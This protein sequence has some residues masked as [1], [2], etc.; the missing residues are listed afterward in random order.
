MCAYICVYES[1][2]ECIRFHACEIR[3]LLQSQNKGW[4][5]L[6]AEASS[7]VLR[8]YYETKLNVSGEAVRT[9][10]FIFS[11]LLAN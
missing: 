3:V 4:H 6:P 10:F 11:R 9:N 8:Y 1:E 7:M 5:K 2:T